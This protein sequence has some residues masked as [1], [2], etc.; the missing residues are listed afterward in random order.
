M[1]MP[2]ALRVHCDEHCGC[3]KPGS[4]R[5][6]NT[7]CPVRVYQDLVTHIAVG[8]TRMKNEGI[9]RPDVVKAVVAAAQRN[10]I[11]LAIIH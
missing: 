7:M 6:H 9:E 8:I 3:L 1:S 2:T 4:T 5:G 11:A 10:D